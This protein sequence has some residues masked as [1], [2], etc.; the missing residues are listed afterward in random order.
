MTATDLL[1]E[2]VLLWAVVDPIGTIPVFLA[3]AANLSAADQRKLAFKAVA[4]A[5]SVLLFFAL[6]GEALL[7]AMGLPLASLQVAGGIILFMFALSMIFGTS[8]PDDEIAQ[9]NQVDDRSI[10]PLAIPSIASPGAILA[11][12]L[13]TDSHRHSLSEQLTS[14]ALLGLVLICVLLLL[15]M[16]HLVYRIIGHGGASLASR[17]MGLLLAAVAA[18]HVMRGITI[19]IQQAGL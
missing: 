6:A 2:F 10:Y 7:Q 16:A 4:I 14:M 18:D 13:M 5:A 1:N 12:V 3:V 8:K 11:T 19:Y 17:I 9:I 15:L